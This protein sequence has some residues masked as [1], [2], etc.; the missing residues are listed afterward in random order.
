LAS[1]A[2]TPASA[3]RAAA[4]VLGQRFSIPL[5]A[6]ETAS[7]KDD[8]GPNGESPNSFA[9]NSRQTKSGTFA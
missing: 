8:A 5:S 4:E 6:D 2:A 1:Y 9:P 3:D 7:E